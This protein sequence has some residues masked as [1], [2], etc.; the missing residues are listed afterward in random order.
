MYG[1]KIKPILEDLE[2]KDIDVAGGGV[3][4]IVL[5]SVNSL[6][7]YIANL[8][9][10]KKKYEDVQDKIKEILEKTSKN[11]LID[12]ECSLEMLKIVLLY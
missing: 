7:R 6:I 9:L 10:G 11:W 2:N 4:G 1:E 5:S 3:V 8:T 12:S